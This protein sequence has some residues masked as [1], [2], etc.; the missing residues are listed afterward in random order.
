[1][2][3]REQEVAT[4]DVQHLLGA[5]HDRYGYDLRGYAEASMRRRVQSALRRGGFASV[6]ELERH[7]LAAAT[8]FANL[9]DQ[10][11]VQV[12]DMFRDPR[13]YRTLR[14]EVVPLLRT[15]PRLA[16]WDCGCASG[17][18]A[19]SLAILLEEEGLYDRCQIY[20][21]DLSPQAIERAREGVYERATLAGLADN[22]RAAGGTRDPTVYFT[23]A[24]DRIAVRAPLRRN[25]VFFQHDVTGDHTFGEMDLVLCRNVLIYFGR[26]LKQRVLGKLAAS[27]RPGGLLCLGPSERLVHGTATRTPFAEFAAADRIYR[28]EVSETG[29]S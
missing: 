26:A 13:F 2:T 11:T 8:S 10:L 3:S 23:P 28:H 24:Y 22:H 14:A 7:A 16:I 12:S 20:A 15:Y 1:M 17:E 6:G 27:L 25:I 21:T 9:L 4:A 29:A 18:E 19:Y 5:I